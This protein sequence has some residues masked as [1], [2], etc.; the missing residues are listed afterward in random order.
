MIAVAGLAFR[1]QVEKASVGVDERV[2]DGVRRV[3]MHLL[4]C[5]RIC[6]RIGNALFLCNDDRN[7][8]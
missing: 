7:G 2:A 5:N 3:G 1:K 8:V 4:V 6:D